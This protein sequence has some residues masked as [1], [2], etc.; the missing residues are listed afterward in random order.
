M[1]TVSKYGFLSLHVQLT[2]QGREVQ[3]DLLERSEYQNSTRV[4]RHEREPEEPKPTLSKYRN[5]AREV[6]RNA[7]RRGRP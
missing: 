1:T 6:V 7:E 4:V 5:S 2:I 3:I